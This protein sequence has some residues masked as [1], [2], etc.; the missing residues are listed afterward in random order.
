MPP[1]GP[2]DLLTLVLR[3]LSLSS[4]FILFFFPTVRPPCILCS[5]LSK[6]DPTSRF[7]FSVL[8][9]ASQKPLSGH[10]AVICHSSSSR[11]HPRQKFFLEVS[12]TPGGQVDCCHSEFFGRQMFRST[13]AHRVR[14]IGP[15]LCP[16]I[17]MNSS[18][19]EFL[20]VFHPNTFHTHSS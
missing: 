7:L 12:L 6:E 8:V 9:Q 20:S 11:K 2:K 3:P 18:T 5:Q 1:C 4:L 17:H 19:A 14:V 16:S 15:G 10:L 13:A